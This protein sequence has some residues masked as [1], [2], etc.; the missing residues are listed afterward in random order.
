MSQGYPAGE[1]HTIAHLGVGAFHRAHQAW[2]THAASDDADPWSI[3]AFTGRSPEQARILQQRRGRYTL[4]TRGI[5]GDEFSQIASIRSAHDGAERAVWDA[6]VADPRTRIIT[7]TITEAGYR[8]ADPAA[9]AATAP[10]R[11]ALGLAARRAADAPPLTVISC[12]NLSGNGEV[13]RSVVLA[14]A[15]AIDPALPGWID[16]NVAFLSSMVDR[17]T[18]QTTAED[19][20]AVER[21]IGIRD[22]GTVVA[23][24]FSEWVIEDGFAGP[25]PAWERAG[26]RMTGDLAPFEER[27]LRILNGAHSLL[28]YQ[29]LLRGFDD[30]AAAFGDPALRARVEQYWAVAAASCR[31]PAAEIDEAIEATRGR[32][33]NPRIRH[34]LAQIALDGAHKLPH[35]IVPVLEH[36]VRADADAGAPASVIAA[37]CLQGG[38]SE[39][40]A[41]AL[42]GDVTD[43]STGAA[44]LAV[45]GR[46][47][48]RLEDD[49]AGA[50]RSVGAVRS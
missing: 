43:S 18:P 32:F 45:I 14:A 31:L 27:K 26:A 15:A 28:A 11:L 38:H 33:A 17:I 1:G 50:S 21:A 12:D 4:I 48:R 20:D 22:A 36:A 34:R 19:I 35:R 47:L 24:P 25:R 44:M 10:A 23:E 13:A 2:Y 7:L 29:G 40:E 9:P 49:P 5:D 46:E 30:V 39:Q 42:L 41:A 16:D 3:V 37:W 6:V 8:V